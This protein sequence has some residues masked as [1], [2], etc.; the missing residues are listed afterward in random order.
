[1]F[2]VSAYRLYPLNPEQGV[3]PLDIGGFSQ[4]ASI[5]LDGR[6]VAVNGYHPREG[7][8]TLTSVPPF[9]DSDRYDPQKVRAYRQSLVTDDGFGVAFE[10]DIV[11]RDVYLIEGA[12]PFLRFTLADENVVECLTIA[13]RTH[14]RQ[15]WRCQTPLTVHLTGEVR[16]MRAAYTQLT[17]GG[18]LS[19]PAP[20]AVPVESDDV[21]CLLFSES[22]NHYAF[23]DGVGNAWEPGTASVRLSG[24]LAI[25]G[26]RT[27]AIGLRTA[28][29]TPDYL[30]TSV[31]D[32]LL[33]R[34]QKQV[35]AA[36]SRVLK[37]AYVYS[38]FCCIETEDEVCSI[39]TDHMILP[40]SWNRDAYYVASVLERVN[41]WDM[42]PSRYNRWLR[43]T[44]WR[45]TFCQT[46]QQPVKAG[47]ARSYLANGMPKDN[48]TYQLD[49]Q[50]F[51]ILQLIMS[52]SESSLRSER[53]LKYDI[54]MMLYAVIT[55]DPDQMLYPTDET[56]ADDEIPLPY[57]FSSYIL[58]WYI[59]KQ[60][61]KLPKENATI[62]TV[63]R[64]L[65]RLYDTIRDIF[66]TNHNN[67]QIFSYATDGTQHYLYHDANDIP[68]VMM[69]L[70][71]FC[72]KNDPVWR[73]TIDFAFSEANPGFYDGVLGS[74]HTPAPWSLGDAQE[75]ILC[76][77]I[78]DRTRYRRVWER[79]E[80]AAQWDGALPE[81]Y[82][83]AT[84]E[85]VSRHW[86]AWPNAMIALADSISW[87][88]EQLNN[89]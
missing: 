42:L 27:L 34:F 57:H 53:H 39:L 56:P 40:L 75:L 22:L 69:P 47:W 41:L 84:G 55:R 65:P 11:Q 21:D 68:L 76:K 4:I 85:V 32:T 78:G 87:E 58:L 54:E 88:W 51:P 8:V 63:I 83:A 44:A 12:V 45:G 23:L 24:T 5:T 71:G 15:I 70:W 74:V 2:D 14:I 31:L 37:R 7:M 35:P 49:Q 80:K 43:Y 17:E 81:A 28:P 82:N 50:F 33:Q 62:A 25:D 10:Q 3:K 64:I 89:V 18:V 6:F 13:D 20:D 29:L 26:E 60:I 48:R 16:L 77:V 9:P 73:N 30:H 52:S 36:D 86:F 19:M 1:M 46:Y 59:D 61:A 79:V 66:T 67:R 38:G 72:D